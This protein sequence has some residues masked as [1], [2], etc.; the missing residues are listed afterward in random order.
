MYKILLLSVRIFIFVLEVEF[1][2]FDLLIIIFYCYIL[3]EGDIGYSVFLIW[4]FIYIVYVYFIVFRFLFW[5]FMVF[6]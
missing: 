5:W 1:V 6:Y 4:L 3:L 2:W